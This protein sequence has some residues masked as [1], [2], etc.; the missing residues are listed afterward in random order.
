MVE[1]L[2][3][4]RARLEQ[5]FQERLL[6]QQQRQEETHARQDARLEQALSY[7]QTLGHAIGQ[8]PPQFLPPPV[9]PQAP[10]YKT[11]NQSATSN[12][13]PVN[14]DMSLPLPNMSLQW[15]QPPHWVPQG[16]VPAFSWP[17]AAPQPRPP[18]P[19]PPPVNE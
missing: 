3:A 2:R 16:F 14:L 4:E 19:P 15:T 7:I 5:Q 9:L 6:A 12:D 10:Y 18:P 11:H 17:S 8:P 13:G 1:R